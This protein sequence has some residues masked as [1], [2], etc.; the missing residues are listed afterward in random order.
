[1]PYSI[2]VFRSSNI[3]PFDYILFINTTLV[4]SMMSA[5]ATYRLHISLV[6]SNP[7]S[8]PSLWKANF[9]IKI[10]NRQQRKKKKN[11]EHP[12]GARL[13][14]TTR[15]RA[16][17]LRSSWTASLYYSPRERWPS[18]TLRSRVPYDRRADVVRWIQFVE[19]W[20]CKYGTQFRLYSRYKDTWTVHQDIR[21]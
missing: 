7:P 21:I 5:A 12:A 4:K 3:L 1:M 10:G 18:L 13:R 15:A 6:P 11:D 16:A 20:Y 2:Q 19:S 8:C 17:C 9:T 14:A